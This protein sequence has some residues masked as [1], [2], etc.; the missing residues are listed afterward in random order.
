MADCLLNSG[1]LLLPGSI[2]EVDDQGGDRQDEDQTDLEMKI[3]PWI[4]H[5]F[6]QFFPAQKPFCP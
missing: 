2:N 3:I 1:K 6:Q 4:L 5:Y